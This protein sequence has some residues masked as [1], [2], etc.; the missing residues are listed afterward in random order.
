MTVL[1]SADD[2]TKRYGGVA[3]VSGV[4]IE[5]RAGEV[6]CVAGE[7]GAGKSTLLKMLAGLAVPDGGAVRIGGERLT[8]HTPAEA[9]G[10]G[11]ALVAQHFALVNAMTGLENIVLAAPPR[12]RLGGFR[13]E[14]ARRRVAELLV[15]LG[16][17]VELDVPVER[18]GVGARQRLEII[19]A[20]YLRARVIL[21]DEPTAVLS[22]GEASA[23]FA[24]LRRLAAGGR[25]VA[26]V[27]HKLSEIAQF[28][29]AVTVLRRGRQT[30]GVRAETRPLAGAVMGEVAHGILGDATSRAPVERPRR[31]G[32]QAQGDLAA[33]LR[34]ARVASGGAPALVDVDLSVGAGEIV[35]VAGVA[36][37][38]QE[39]LCAVLGGA[40]PL[41]AGEVTVPRGVAIVH[42]DRQREGLCL[43]ASIRDNLV[44]GEHGALSRWG[45][46]D[47]AKIDV[48]AATR[49]RSLGVRAGDADTVDLDLPAGA[50]SGG[51]QQK[52]VC[53]RAFAAASRGVGLLVLAQPT[54]GVDVGAA[55]AIRQGIAEAAA[56]GAGVVL[57][58]ADT[59]ELR[60]LSDRILVFFRGRATELGP[61]A[62][63]EVLGRAMLGEVAS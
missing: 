7:N 16:A 58:S 29:D 59:A 51:N 42:E 30:Y 8:A 4:S 38:G 57:V 62:S 52:V 37:N 14:D 56:R 36:G 27:T 34:G 2:L 47:V 26:V 46:L 10:R 5:L 19:R 18:L 50:L 11:V 39:A 12:G 61:D 1:A 15:E 20:L 6:H 44:L 3:V 17:E 24:L 45:L 33:I 22:P 32:R 40:L 48:E 63:D 49:A 54:R 28:S 9:M 53:A 41:D 13:P 25:G 21:L 35:G 60:E 31:Q 43:G 23:L 55:R